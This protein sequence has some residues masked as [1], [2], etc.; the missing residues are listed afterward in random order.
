MDRRSFLPVLL[1]AGAAMASLPSITRSAAQ[2]RGTPEFVGIDG[3]LN[4]PAPL[5]ITGLRGEVVL[6]D[7]WTY[8]CI[9]CRRTVSYLNRW[10]AEYGP[11][12]LQ[13]CR[14]PHAQIR[15]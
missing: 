9:N 5:T 12:G 6:V 2:S 4:S 8:S 11:Y 3:W 15:F 13:G 1:A 7:F 10:Q 14:H